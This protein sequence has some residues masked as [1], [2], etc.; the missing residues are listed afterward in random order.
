M[1]QQQRCPGG[2]G[3][4]TRRLYCP[5]WRG[6]CSGPGESV[7]AAPASSQPLHSALFRAPGAINRGL[8]SGAVALARPPPPVS[9]APQRLPGRASPR[10][11]L[12]AGGDT[13]RVTE[14]L[15][16]FPASR[17]F[18]PAS[19]CLLPR[20]SWTELGVGVPIFSIPTAPAPGARK[21]RSW[22]SGKVWEWSRGRTQ[23]SRENWGCGWPLED[24][25]AQLWEPGK[26]ELRVQKVNL[27]IECR[28]QTCK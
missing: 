5:S 21:T 26:F 24:S 22:D 14:S 1:S 9:P 12:E 28:N 15:G 16:C 8:W 20:A 11:S 4:G 25:N 19:V 2:R 23:E 3:V 6:C 27:R 10:L 13:G 17:A 18:V 7:P